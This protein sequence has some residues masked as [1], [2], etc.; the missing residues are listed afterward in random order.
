VVLKMRYPARFEPAPEGGYIVRFRDIPEAITQGETEEEAM[1]MAADVLSSALDFYREDERPAP[2]PT[3]A[4]KGEILIE[5]PP[6][7]RGS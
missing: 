3:K 1:D 5:L 2:L 4:R 7:A 6:G